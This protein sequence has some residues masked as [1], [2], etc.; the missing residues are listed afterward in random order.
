MFVRGT[1]CAFLYGPHIETKL[2]RTWLTQANSLV[3]FVEDIES[4]VG[5]EFFLATELHISYKMVFP[6]CDI[7]L[8]G[9]F[10]A[11][12]VPMEELYLFIKPPRK[13]VDNGVLA[14]ELPFDPVT[15]HLAYFWSIHPDGREPLDQA[16]LDIY[17]P[18]HIETKIE[19]WGTSWTK[20][21]YKI[22][23]DVMRREGYNPTTT[24]YA[25]E[26]GIPEPIFH[27]VTEPNYLVE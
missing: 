11:D 1:Q 15:S 19:V 16:D 20:E 7:T 14:I 2:Q 23:A 17:C 5:Q 22:I 18:P 8:Q 6:D 4:P 13:Y 12:E 25:R 27:T 24:D 3:S 26:H 9:T 10:M 21:D